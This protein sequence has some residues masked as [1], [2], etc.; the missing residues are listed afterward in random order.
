MEAAL[1]VGISITVIML[2]ALVFDRLRLPNILGVLVAGILMGPYSPLANTEFLGIDFGSI[3]ITEP[4]LIDV[5]AVI[6]SALILF[7]IGIE[8]S[9]AK[10]A[11]LGAFTFPAAIIKIGTVYLVAHSLLVLFGFGQTEAVLVAIALSFASTP[12]MIKLV[13]ARGGVRRPEIPFI[14]SM[15]VIEDLLAVFCLGLIAAPPSEANGYSF[16]LSLVRVML[17]FI[18]TYLILSK[19]INRFLALVSHSDELLILSTVSLV[20]VIGYVSEGIGLSFSVGAF[21]AG[22]VIASSQESRKVEERIRPFNS[23]FSSFFFFS[24]GLLVNINA[25]FSNL[26]VLFLFIFASVVV[27]F[28]ASGLAA[29]FAGFTGRSACFCAAS[30]LPLSEL[31]LLIISQGVLS[32]LVEPD[33]IGSFAFAIITSS[34]VSAWLVSREN[35]TYNFLQAAC[36]QLIINNLRLLRSTALGMR[37][38]VSETSKY[39]RVVE[40]LPS[41]SSHTD[42]FSTREQMVLTAK[43]AAILIIVSFSCYLVLFFMQSSEWQFLDSFFVFVFSGFLVSS[44]LFLVNAKSAI[45]LL[46]KMMVRSSAGAKYAAVGHFISCAFF[47]GFS[48]LYFWAYAFA[49]SSLSVILVLPSLAFAARSFATAIRLAFLGKMMR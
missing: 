26:P 36:P 43:N 35:E 27:N 31:S 10:I 19:V 39:Y 28:V 1:A 24:I 41:I 23:L 4:G 12:I 14:V 40:K 33:L 5:F 30:L 8:F 13:E 15:L 29:Y 46:I 48:A 47:L 20:L 11:Q 9:I 32:G 44:A 45:S 42:Q 21:L 37:R 34:F 3:I 18:F 16:V 2:S 22:S 25:V 38:A 6:G 49:P 7:G 17:T